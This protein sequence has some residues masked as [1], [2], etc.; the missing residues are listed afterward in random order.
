MA[1]GNPKG[2]VARAPPSL[3]QNRLVRADV[4]AK[5]KADADAEVA[6]R[7]E[8]ELK[9]KKQKALE[10]F[11]ASQQLYKQRDYAAAVQKL[12]MAISMRPEMAR[13]YFARGN[14][15][16]K[17]DDWQRA[18]VGSRLPRLDRAP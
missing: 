2:A 1:K 12:T 11:Q 7:E 5:A 8:K 6:W 13:Y 15:Y 10:S 3:T 9:K 18:Q 14:C 17:L 4:K 16:S